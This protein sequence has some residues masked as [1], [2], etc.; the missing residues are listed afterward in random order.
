ME[1]IKLYKAPLK[2][3]ENTLV[4]V[5]SKTKKKNKQF[6]RCAYLFV[7]ERIKH[8]ERKHAKNCSSADSFKSNSELVLYYVNSKSVFIA[9]PIQKM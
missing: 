3:K 2:K 8:S 6:I 7:C 9:R 1:I 5:Q 4:L